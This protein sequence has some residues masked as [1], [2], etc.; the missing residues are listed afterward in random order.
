[1]PKRPA[2]A[3]TRKPQEG[4]VAPAMPAPALTARPTKA[5]QQAE[6]YPSLHRFPALERALTIL[7]QMEQ[8]K[9][10]PEAEAVAD[11]KVGP[12]S[13]RWMERQ[14]ARKPSRGKRPEPE[15]RVRVKPVRRVP[16]R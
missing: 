2:T 10:R 1:M 14:K 8:G 12:R 11:R 3:R 5:Q 16:K 9:P 15:K 13:P 7:R 6:R 4:P